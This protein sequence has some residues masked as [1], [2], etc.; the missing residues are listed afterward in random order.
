MTSLVLPAMLPENCQNAELIAQ[1]VLYKALIVVKGLA[2]ILS[3]AILTFLAF[4]KAQ[5]RIFHPNTKIIALVVCAFVCLVAAN[6]TLTNMLEIW[7]ISYPYD[8]PCDRLWS[9]RS[10]F[11]LR[12]M[13]VIFLNGVNSSLIVLCIERF[14]CIC[15]ISNYEKSSKP[16]LVAVFLVITTAIFSVIFTVFYASG[17]DWNERIA[18]T[19]IRN[20]TNGAFYQ[21]VLTYVEATEILGVLFFLFIHYWSLWYRKRVRGFKSIAQRSDADTIPRNETLSVKFQIEETLAITCLFLPVV[22]IKLAM[23]IF[24]FV[25]ASIANAIWPN[26]PA[27][28]QMIIY[29]LVNVGAVSPLPM[30]LLL[31]HGT[32]QLSR[33]FCCRAKTSTRISPIVFVT[34]TNSSQEEYFDRLKQL[35]ERNAPDP[36]KKYERSSFQSMC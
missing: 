29:Q 13:Y 34:N 6:V 30:A 12:S 18:V 31:A 14:V 15:R 9:I 8:N 5:V 21:I 10:I 24:T 17:V 36:A 11:C 22:L 28:I 19:T 3:I 4:S 33:L 2:C 7:R 35:F 26:P 16:V 25:S 1:S 20:Q 27:N 23:G 32:G